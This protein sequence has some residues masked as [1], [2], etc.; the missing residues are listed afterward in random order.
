MTKSYE[1]L[2]SGCFLQPAVQTVYHPDRAL[3]TQAA[4]AGDRDDVW[5]LAVESARAR[6][7]DL[8]DG[9]LY[10]L[11]GYGCSERG[12]VLDLGPTTYREYVITRTPSSGET[13]DRS[14]MADPIAVCAALVTADGQLVVAR[15][16]RV[17]VYEGRLHVIGGFVDR[18]AE[19]PPPDPFAA[20]AREVTEETG[21]GIAP[22]QFRLLGLAY[23]LETPHPELCFSVLVDTDSGSLSSLVWATGSELGEL[24]M[25]PVEQSAFRG[26]LS[27][28]RGPLSPT[29]AACVALLGREQF[30]ETWFAGVCPPGQS[31]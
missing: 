21:L 4:R 1:I 29:G 8:Y 2:L 27:G 15:R 10:R 25:V 30:G 12:V 14:E 19:P 3:K 5:R 17:D 23:D 31:A 24:L 18:D 7:A 22:A 20:V 6:G 13:R 28:Q 11:L 16:L 9:L 26:L